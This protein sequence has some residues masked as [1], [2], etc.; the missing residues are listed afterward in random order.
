MLLA[1]SINLEKDAPFLH[2]V[3]FKGPSGT[4]QVSESHLVEGVYEEGDIRRAA[5]MVNNSFLR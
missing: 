4:A 2:K 3:T 5:T 1:S